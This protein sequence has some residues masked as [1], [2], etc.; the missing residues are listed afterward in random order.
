MGD[1][2]QGSAR[3]RLLYRGQRRRHSDVADLDFELGIGDSRA[4][5]GPVLGSELKVAV[6]GPVGKEMDNLGEIGLGVEAMQ[7]SPRSARPVT[8]DKGH[9]GPYSGAM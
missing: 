2:E 3:R 1:V 8:V 5:G 4:G 6:A 9:L 7:L